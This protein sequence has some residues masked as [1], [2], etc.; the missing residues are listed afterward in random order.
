[1]GTM[2]EM[3]EIFTW[4]EPLQVMLKDLSDSRRLDSYVHS[5]SR[6]ARMI[7]EP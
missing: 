7:L 5:E 6:K 3:N 4:F 1:M 2:I